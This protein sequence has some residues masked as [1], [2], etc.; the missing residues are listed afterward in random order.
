VAVGDFNGDG[1]ADLAVADN[2]GGVSAL[3][4]NGD[5]TF[6]PAVSYPAGENPTSVAV[7][8]FNGDGKA[9]LAVANNSG[10][11]HVLLGDFP[12][13]MTLNAGTTPQTATVG[14]AFGV[15]LAVTV[16]DAASSPLAGVPVTFTAPGSGASGL[17]SNSTATMVVA[18]NASGIASAPFSANASPGGP[19]NVSAA[20]SRL[21]VTFALTNSPSAFSLCDV[22]QDGTTIVL[23]VQQEVNEALGNSPAASALHQIGA[24]NIVDVQIVIDAVGGLGCSAN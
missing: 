21:S 22:N 18:T 16:R 24:V 2:N 14:T 15:A 4:G 6:Q 5:G 12:A 17:F 19:Y 23:D 20:I 1:I 8:D 3:L 11:V 13:T 10:G 9:D 7:G